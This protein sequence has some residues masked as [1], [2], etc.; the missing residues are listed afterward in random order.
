MATHCQTAVRS[1]SGECQSIGSIHLKGKKGGGQRQTEHLIRV[2]PCKM[3]L[4]SL[5]FVKYMICITLHALWNDWSTFC[6]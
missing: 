4:F 1:G 6:I 2:V 3:C 5:Y